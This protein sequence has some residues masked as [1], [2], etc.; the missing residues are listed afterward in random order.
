VLLICNTIAKLIWQR[1][2]W[3][4]DNEQYQGQ[5]EGWTGNVGLVNVCKPLRARPPWRGALGGRQDVERTDN[6][7]QGPYV[8]DQ[9]HML[10]RD[11]ASER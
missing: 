9:G 4:L 1:L 2:L 5:D 6:T 3:R 10:C 7:N 8:Y 11:G